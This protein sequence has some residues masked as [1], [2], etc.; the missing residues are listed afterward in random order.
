MWYFWQ[1]WCLYLVPAVTF[2]RLLPV[3]VTDRN[4]AYF[5]WIVVSHLSQRCKALLLPP[6]WVWLA[7][8]A[9]EDFSCWG[10]N[11]ETS[12]YWKTTGHLIVFII[13]VVIWLLG[14]HSIF[15]QDQRNKDHA[16]T[17]NRSVCWISSDSDLWC[18]SECTGCM[19]QPWYTNCIVFL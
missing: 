6:Q 4:S 12:N 2:W 10:W 13:S 15:L 16:V 3:L 19:S 18:Y 9:F 17:I 11:D 7:S 14:N 5:W 8:S 1:C